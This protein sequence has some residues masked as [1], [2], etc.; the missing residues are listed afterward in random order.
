M[1]NYVLS[2]NKG[3][4]KELNLT[5]LVKKIDFDNLWGAQTQRSLENFKIGNE[6]IPKR[7]N[8]IYWSTKKSI[9]SSKC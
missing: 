9:G 6:K 8:K 7:N 2:N 3:N 5:V 4:K 1:F